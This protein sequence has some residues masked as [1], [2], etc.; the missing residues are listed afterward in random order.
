MTIEKI[1]NW[2]KLKV[3]NWRKLMLENQNKR[4]L[5]GRGSGKWEI[6]KKGYRENEYWEKEKYVKIENGKKQQKQKLRGGNGEKR[7]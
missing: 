2:E 4:F 3:G 1:E 5:L 6:M 7:K